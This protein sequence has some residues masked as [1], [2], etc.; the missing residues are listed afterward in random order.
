MALAVLVDII[1]A[2]NYL[3][4]SKICKALVVHGEP[5]YL[6]NII[7]NYL[8]EREITYTI[9]DSTQVSRSVTRGNPQGSVLGPTMWN[10]KYN[11]VLEVAIPSR[12]QEESSATPSSSRGEE[13]DSYAQT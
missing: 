12:V 13:V 8:L 1:N 2:F 7:S 9:E 10:I 4:W 6:R 5:R 3:L 11:Q